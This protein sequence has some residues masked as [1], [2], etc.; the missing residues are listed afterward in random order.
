MR[1]TMTHLAASLLAA[2][3]MSSSPLIAGAT[4]SDGAVAVRP[5]LT[6]H[7]SLGDIVVELDPA[8]APDVVEWLVKLASGPVFDPNFG[9]SPTG[10]WDGL[11]I[12]Y[13]HPH[14][15]IVTAARPPADSFSI[16]TEIDASA[17]GLDTRRVIDAAEAVNLIQFE[18]GPAYLELRGNVP[19]D[20]AE[21]IKRWELSN[22][23]SFLIGVDYQRVF[24]A[25][26]YHYRPGLDSRPVERGTV[27][28]KPLSRRTSSPRLSIALADM[29]RRTGRW[30]VVGRVVEGLDIAEAIS[31][32]PPAGQGSGR[33]KR[34][35]PLDP[36][37]ISSTEISHAKPPEELDDS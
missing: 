27:S 26:G 25:M 9:S 16:T 4:T 37:V 30:M 7:T 23:A 32:R 33:V 22:D 21:W 31:V 29:P 10:Y 17:L 3:S 12:D 1:R 35:Q 20:L 5:L 15:E 18:L 19:A 34:R 24:E 6:L 13:A 36:I 2:L 11:P 8:A 28:L 14:V